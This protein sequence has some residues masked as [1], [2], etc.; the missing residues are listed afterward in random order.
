M[1][2]KLPDK[3]SA[4]TG[5]NVT[6]KYK[7]DYSCPQRLVPLSRPNAL[8]VHQNFPVRGTQPTSL[9]A[10]LGKKGRAGAAV[11]VSLTI[12][13]LLLVGLVQ[14]IRIPWRKH[15]VSQLPVSTTQMVLNLTWPCQ[16][17]LYVVL[18]L[19]CAN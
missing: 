8:P 9:P 10:G 2:D 12:G 7:D 4:A 6:E 5:E 1:V 18:H 3:E 14:T 15:L 11:G 19:N 13:T 16:H 17:D